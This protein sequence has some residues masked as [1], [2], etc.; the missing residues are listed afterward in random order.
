M[1]TGCTHLKQQKPKDSKVIELGCKNTASLVTVFI[2]EDDYLVM[3]MPPGCRCFITYN[4]HE[5]I[6]SS[7][8]GMRQC[9]KE[10]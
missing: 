4:N 9:E 5:Y 2:E 3:P 10:K 1:S 7:G 6:S 8:L